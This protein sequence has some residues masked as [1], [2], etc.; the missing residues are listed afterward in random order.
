MADQ[1]LSGL[2]IPTDSRMV[3]A[4]MPNFCRWASSRRRW[5][6]LAGWLSVVHKSPREGQ[7]GICGVAAMKASAAGFPPGSVNV[8]IAPNRWPNNRRAS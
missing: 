8:T 3:P 6:V 4:V 5:L 7:K 1:M 2:S